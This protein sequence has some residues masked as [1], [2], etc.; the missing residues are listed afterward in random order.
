MTPWPRLNRLNPLVA[1]P[2]PCL[3]PWESRRA[4]KMLS[5]P[6]NVAFLAHEIGKKIYEF[7]LRPVEDASEID[8]RLTPAQIGLDS[9]MAI[10]L[11][12]WFKR[13]FGIVMSVREIMDSGSLL[14]LGGLMATIVGAKIA[15]K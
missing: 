6:E 8:T 15:V 9:L 1:K 3:R 4:S 14:Q 13:V 2:V 5:D 12:P 7:M 10:E 11:K